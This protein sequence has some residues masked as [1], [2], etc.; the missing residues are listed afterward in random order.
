MSSGSGRSRGTRHTAV[1]LAAEVGGI[2]I[3][4][5]N[6]A[7]IINRPFESFSITEYEEQLRVNAGAAFGSPQAVAPG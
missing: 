4:V 2:D 3:L 7:M 5:N 6:A 1:A